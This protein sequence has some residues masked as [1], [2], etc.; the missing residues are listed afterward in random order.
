MFSNETC[1][2]VNINRCF[3]PGKRQNHHVRRSHARNSVNY[4]YFEYVSV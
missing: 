1:I 4:D 3:T 2:I